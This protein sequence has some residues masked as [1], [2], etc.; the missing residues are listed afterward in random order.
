MIM[1]IQVVGAS[2]SLWLLSYTPKSHKGERNHNDD[3]DQDAHEWQTIT[4]A[5]LEEGD[6]GKH[7]HQRRKPWHWWTRTWFKS[8]MILCCSL[9]TYQN[10]MKESKTQDDHDNHYWHSKDHDKTNNTMREGGCCAHFKNM[11]KM[12]MVSS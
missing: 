8:F 10:P 6:K 3:Q 5:W 7:V 4:Q 12:M 1:T 9:L 11:M 2:C